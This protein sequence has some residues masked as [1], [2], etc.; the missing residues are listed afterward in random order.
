MQFQNVFFYVHILEKVKDVDGK[1]DANLKNSPVRLTKL[2]ISKS[3]SKF[4]F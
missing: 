4:G 3:N 1:N 2:Y